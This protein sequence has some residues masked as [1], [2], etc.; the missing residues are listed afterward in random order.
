MLLAYVRQSPARDDQGEDSRHEETSDAAA[1][2]PATRSTRVG[3]GRRISRREFVGGALAVVAGAP[4]ILR[5]QNLN[6]KLNIAVIGAGGR[7]GANL[8]GVR[9]ENIVAL[10]DVNAVTLD[11]A[12][13]ES[14]AGEEVHRLP[15]ALRPRRASSTPSSS[16][17]A[18]T[19]TPSPRCRRCKLGKHVYCEKPLTHNI[20]EARVDPRGGGEGQGRHADGH[21]DPR[22]ATTTAASSS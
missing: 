9:S 6:N 4:A 7:G 1:R 14:S 11:R 8:S 5:G 18:S 16:A 10:C 2:R 3:I 12:A 13:P 19:R 20:W 15:Q 22:R 21:P 17:P